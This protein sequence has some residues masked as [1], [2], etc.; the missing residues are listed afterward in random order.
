MN[1]YDRR[2]ICTSFVAMVPRKYAKTTLGGLV[3]FEGFFFGDYDYEGYCVANSAEQSSILFR[4][5]KDMIHQL[6][7]DEERIR[8]TATQVNWKVGQS[9]AASIT[10]LTAGGKAK[11]GV[12]AQ[13]VT[14]DEFGASQRVKGKSSDMEGLINVIEG[15]MGTRREHLSM[16]TSTAGLGL[17]TPYEQ[18][19]NSIEID[20]LGELDIPLD[21][22]AHERDNDWQM[23]FILRPDLWERDEQFLRTERVT[24]KVNPHVGITI[25]PD[26]YI[27]EWKEVDMKGDAKRKE[28]ITKLYNVFQA[29][30]VVEWIKPDDIRKLQ[31][32]IR[33]D[34]L[35]SDDGWLAFVGMDFS[36]GNDLHAQTY[37]CYN[38][39]TGEFFADLDGWITQETLENSSIRSLYEIWI[40]Q[41]WLHLS[42]GRTLQPDLP[43]NRII[44]L[45]E[46]ISFLRFGYDPYKAKDPI[47]TL[48]SWIYTMGED[49]KS[50]VRPVRQN[51]ATYNPAVLELDYMVRNN[52]PL[53][54]FS[55]NPLWP[56]EF[57]CVALDESSDGMENHKPI[58]MNP[59]SDG[60]KVDHVQ[61][62]CSAL[63]LY[64]E[65]NGING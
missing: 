21:G 10:A 8:F 4:M 22:R 28:V 59:G 38:R 57:G 27:N 50:Y 53:I 49:P 65:V 48:S 3:Q 64:D 30:K 19:I 16:H 63:I 35:N 7:P 26:Y 1:I 33:I 55:P 34:D 46:H 62:L 15:S 11:D 32:D 2:R 29:D 6:D 58:K 20:L 51:Y 23:S 18:L 9:R 60:C 41:G 25:Q 31:T 36:L 14:N 54:H 12:K 43:I 5:A 47:N 13:Y 39:N 44:E 42:P 24:R 61:C 52:P 40:E 17:N 56:Y 45:S 37:L